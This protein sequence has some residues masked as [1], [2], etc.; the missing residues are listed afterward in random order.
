MCSRAIRKGNRV[1]W[2]MPP[3][4]E[5]GTSSSTAFDYRSLLPGA[6]TNYLPMLNQKIPPVPHSAMDD[7][8][9]DS[10]FERNDSWWW[11]RNGILGRRNSSNESEADEEEWCCADLTF[12]ERLLG[13]GTCVLSG[14]MLSFGSFWRIRDLLLGNPYP[15]VLHTALGNILSWIGSF[16]LVG[17][18]TQWKR[19]WHPKRKL[20]TQ[21][22]LGSLLLM[23]LVVLFHPIGPEGLYL[24]LLILVQNGAMT[25]YCLSYIP[26]AQDLIQRYAYR[27]VDS[28]VNDHE[29]NLTSY[30]PAPV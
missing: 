29:L 14:Y 24:F 18:R 13:F 21:M 26:F 27:I 22:Y 7:P 25:W 17:P 19:L 2:K 1:V 23:L 28:G 9:N 8:A 11:N 20:A 4:A 15:L 5:A 16:F 6:S 12:R 10:S 30:M 3:L